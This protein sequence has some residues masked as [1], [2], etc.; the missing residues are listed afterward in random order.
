MEIYEINVDG[1][2][3]KLSILTIASSGSMVIKDQYCFII[4]SG[5][6]GSFINIK[7][8]KIDISDVYNPVIVNQIEYPELEYCF[9][10][11]KFGDYLIFKWFDLSGNNYDFIAFPK[12]NMQVISFRK[13][14]ITL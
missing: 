8:N 3:N 14:I 4:S 6:N 9:G 10:I 13:I 2:I 1:N 12:W 11:F 5:F 7:I